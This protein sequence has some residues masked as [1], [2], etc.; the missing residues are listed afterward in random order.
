[1]VEPPDRS[2]VYLSQIPVYLVLKYLAYPS[3]YAE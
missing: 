3:S 1:M 2:G